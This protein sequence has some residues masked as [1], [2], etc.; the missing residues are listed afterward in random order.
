M[1]LFYKFNIWS[2]IVV[3]KVLVIDSENNSK[4]VIFYGLYRLS[5]VMIRKCLKI[6][7]IIMIFI[8]SFKLGLILNGVVGGVLVVL[9][10][11]KLDVEVKSVDVVD[12]V[13]VLKIF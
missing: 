4:L 9:F 2:G 3:F 8:I 5:V 12:I 6:N 1:K 10:I 13:I 7:N 11:E